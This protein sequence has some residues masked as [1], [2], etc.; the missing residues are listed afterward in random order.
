MG[1]IKFIRKNALGIM[2]L[3]NPP[4]NAIGIELIDELEATLEEIKN[5]GIRGLIF[6]AL[7]DNFSAGAD[8]NIFMNRSPEQAKEMFGDFFNLLHRFETLP[9]PT[10]AVVNGLCLTAGLEA[11]LCMDMI[12][13]ADT[14]VFAQAEAIIGGL[15]F[16]GGTQRLAAR[17]GSARAKEIVFSAQFYP[18]QKFFDYNIINRILPAQDLEK[19]AEKFMQNMADNGPTLAFAATKKI[20]KCFEDEGITPADQKTQDLGATMFDTKDFQNG[21]QSFLKDGP[22]KAIF[23][24]E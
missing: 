22:G 11:A 24:G 15:P 2:T 5:S 4:V 20:I 9:I 6:N 1:K 18:A 12:W 7:G 16:G 14:A 23:K 17:A 21:I 10:M 13:A 8:V 19:K 3:D